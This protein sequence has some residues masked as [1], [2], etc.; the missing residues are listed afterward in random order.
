MKDNTVRYCRDCKHRGRYIVGGFFCQRDLR[1]AWVE[2]LVY[3][4]YLGLE[5]ESWYCQAERRGPWY[6]DPGIFTPRRRWWQ[7]R[8]SPPVEQHEYCGPEGRFFEPRET[9]DS[10]DTYPPYSL[11]TEMDGRKSV[12]E[13]ADDS[14]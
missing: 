9:E 3:G 12:A 11:F 4:R 13:I 10:T 1:E 8:P 14:N 6:E 7:R 5:G 2:D